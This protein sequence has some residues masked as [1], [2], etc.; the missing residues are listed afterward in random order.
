MF[1]AS[2]NPP[3]PFTRKAI[4]GHF[5]FH[6]TNGPAYVQIQATNAL[7]RLKGLYQEARQLVR[8]AIQSQPQEQVPKSE[9]LI[10]LDQAI[11]DG[12]D[13]RDFSMH[14][15]KKHP[16]DEEEEAANPEEDEPL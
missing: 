3:L 4:I 1:V 15:K 16:E 10:A 12:V 11:A 9:K 5:Q 7:A 8:T 14:A 6:A 13:L 2:A